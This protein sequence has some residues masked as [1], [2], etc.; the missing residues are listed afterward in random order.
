ML[1]GFFVAGL[2]VAEV[3]KVRWTYQEDRDADLAHIVQV[4]NEKTGLKLTTK[5]FLLIEN[6]P[7]AT[8]YFQMY[9][10]QAGGLPVQG[11]VIRVWTDLKK[12]ETIQ[13]EAHVDEEV[14]QILVNRWSKTPRLDSAGTVQLVKSAIKEHGEDLAIR[15]LK[16]KDTWVKNQV[17]RVV[18]VKSRRGIHKVMISVTDQKVVDHRYEPFQQADAGTQ[19]QGKYF[20]VPALV[21]PIW[22]EYEGVP[23][24]LDS[25][26]KSELRYLMREVREGGENPYQALSE[27]KKYLET[28]LDP[29]RGLTE[30]GRKLGFWAMSYVKEQA[31]EIYRKLPVVENSFNSGAILEGKYTTVSF[32]PSAMKLQGIQFAL[33]ASSQ[34]RPNWVYTDASNETMEMIPESGLLGRPLYSI[35]DAYSRVAQRLSDNNPVQYINDGFDEV[36]VYWAVTQLFDSLRPMGFTDPELSTRRF[37][38]YLYDTDISMRDNAYY[39]DDTINFTTYSS[40]THNMARDNTTIWHELG[41]GVMDRL[42]GDHLN[43]ADTGGLSEGMADFIA[44]LVVKDVTQGKDFVGAEKMRILNHTGFYLTSESHDD[45]EAYG[46][47]M[48][49]ILDKAMAKD[50]LLG[51]RKVSDLTL[52]AM[53]LTRNHPELTANDWFS[54]M[55]FADEMGHGDLRRPGELKSYILEALN[56]RNFSLEGA[57]TASFA[58]LNGS[59]EVLSTGPGSRN[60]PIVARLKAEES[61][62]YALSVR[63]KNSATYQ[64]RFP[65][66]IKVQL[67][68]GPIQGAIHWKNE[69]DKPLE[70]VLRSEEDT[71][72]IPMAVTGTCDEV[73]RPDGSCVDYAYVQI[74][75]QGETEEAQAKKRFYI[76]VIPQQ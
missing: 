70:Y 25:R 3:K 37:H 23:V 58:L 36:Q 51:L 35:D 60:Q 8:S 54:H 62:E 42:M 6:R 44:Q 43:L 19:E 53:R 10:Q 17:M 16:W 41:H 4:V 57:E 63:L 72:V 15:D 39:T 40:Q 26:I 68:Q 9:V 73:N 49:D 13:V 20:S 69:S 55:L 64:F 28:F 5:N 14:P 56:G 74:W 27:G 32:H 65:V 24:Q 30:E 21:Y 1:I 61:A 52:E 45:G 12:R 18:R 38:A 31:Q 34:F 59:D 11:Q 48:N 29:I 66:T 33:K 46:G 50:G 76:R 75:N 47:T 7:L 67:R 22:E 71:A 2:S